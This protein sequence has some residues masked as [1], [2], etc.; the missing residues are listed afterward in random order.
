MEHLLI[1]HVFFPPRII[2][3]PNL[4]QRYTMGK[5]LPSHCFSAR[6]NE[7]Q[8]VSR[9]SIFPA[10]ILPSPK[11]ST[12]MS[13]KCLYVSWET[14]CSCVFMWNWIGHGR[15]QVHAYCEVETT[16]SADASTFPSIVSM[17]NFKLHGKLPESQNL[18]SAN[19]VVMS[20]CLLVIDFFKEMS[21]SSCAVPSR[22]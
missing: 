5:E 17:Q 14:I 8:A 20:H 1:Y 11:S 22:D 4:L 18:G 12:Q 19:L 13:A 2:C 3:V 6:P 7:K 21:E 10:I 9:T 15:V 16:D